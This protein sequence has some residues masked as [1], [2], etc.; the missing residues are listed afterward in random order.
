MKNTGIPAFSIEM[1]DSIWKKKVQNARY[2]DFSKGKKL[3]I[4]FKNYY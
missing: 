2:V 3:K 4:C 1:E